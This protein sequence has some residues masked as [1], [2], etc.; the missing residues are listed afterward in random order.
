MSFVPTLTISQLA[1]EAAVK[2]TT[3]RYYERRGLLPAPSRSV[4]GYRL[5]PDEAVR[6]L[7]FI[8][9]AQDL[10][11]TLKEI[12]ELLGLIAKR[13][14]SAEVCTVTSMKIAAVDQK[15]RQL[16]ALKKQLK[17]L[18]ASCSRKGTAEECVIMKHL[19]A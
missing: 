17:V 9:H 12:N 15:I 8:K 10:G 2:S 7:R 4:S 19:Y 3:V 16:K 11:F 1:K 6:R 14:S 13:R 18:T 5:Y